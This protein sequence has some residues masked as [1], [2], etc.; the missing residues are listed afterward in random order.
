[1]LNM[2]KPQATIDNE[3]AADKLRTAFDLLE[4]ARD[5][6]HQNIYR[7]NPEASPEEIEE[8]LWEWINKTPGILKI[9]CSE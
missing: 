3:H 4:L 6:M 7:K 8:Q 2:N 1:M 5:I 9:N